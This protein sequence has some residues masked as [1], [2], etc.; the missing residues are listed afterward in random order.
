M[1]SAASPASQQTTPARRCGRP[2]L[3]KN[4]QLFLPVSIFSVSLDDTDSI[5]RHDGSVAIQ[6]R[7]AK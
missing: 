4:G 6:R 5:I 2:Q 7:V 1:A 3:P